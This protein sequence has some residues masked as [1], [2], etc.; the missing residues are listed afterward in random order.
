MD[1]RIFCFWTDDTPMSKNR[2]EGL[3]S[4]KNK[5]GLSIQFIDNSN[6]NEFIFDN[7]PLPDSYKY[8]SA[9]HKAD[10]LRCYFMHYYGGG[11]SDIKKT[12]GNWQLSWNKLFNDDNLWISGYKEVGPGGVAHKDYTHLWESL[13]GNA[14]YICKPKTPFTY[15]WYGRLK[16]KIEQFSSSLAKF[17]ATKPRDKKEDYKFNN[18]YPIEWNEILGR[19]FHPLVYKY[20]DHV[21]MS[22]PKLIFT[23]YK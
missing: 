9:V 19:I 23:N 3:N 4:L 14:C 16:N 2:L 10:Y 22:L 7:D 21:D 8:L 6:L 17:P 20:K 11:Y 18:C 15:E 13:I 5:S 12:T 1:K